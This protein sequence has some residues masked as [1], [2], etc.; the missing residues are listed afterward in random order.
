MKAEQGRRSGNSEVGVA[1]RLVERSEMRNK[2]KE[3]EVKR[4]VK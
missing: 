1:V 3:R 2:L 4:K